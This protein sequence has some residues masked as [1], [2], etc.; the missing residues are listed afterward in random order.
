MLRSC[1]A[2]AKVTP[3]HKMVT[4][5]LRCAPPAELGMTRKPHKRYETRA[6]DGQRTGT[7]RPFPLW[8]LPSG[9][10][11]RPSIQIY[12]GVVSP[13]ARIAGHLTFHPLIRFRPQ[14]G[15]LLILPNSVAGLL[16]TAD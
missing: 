10:Y 3:R 15:F 5:T 2:C 4:K 14:R 11:H 12:S 7:A 16:H 9:P 1:C 13:Q 6:I 8:R